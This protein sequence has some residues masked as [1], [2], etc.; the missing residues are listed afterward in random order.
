[1]PYR[2]FMTEHISLRWNIVLTVK[3]MLHKELLFTKLPHHRF[4]LQIQSSP[5]AHE[6][7][8]DSAWVDKLIFL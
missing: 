8:I 2:H 1:M 7:V 5:N 6:K 4:I 3:H